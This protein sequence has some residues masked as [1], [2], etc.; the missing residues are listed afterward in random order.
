MEFKVIDLGLVDFATAWQ[1]QKDMFYKVRGKKLESALLICR[2]EPVITLGRKADKKNIIADQTKLTQSGIK[3]YEVERGGDVTYHGPGQII[4]YPVFNLANLKKDI[5]FFLRQLEKVGMSLLSDFGVRACRLKD[6]T[7]IW[8]QGKKIASI[9]IAVRN[10]I[11]FHGMSIN[12]KK[13]DLANFAL[14]NPCGM[15]INMTSLE[16]ILDREISLDQAKVRLID[17]IKQVFK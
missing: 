5:H 9:G 2:H 10:W 3:V 15:D 6:F 8:Y 16:T 4:A 1:Y 7:G 12:I 14:I 13:D 17:K 11:S